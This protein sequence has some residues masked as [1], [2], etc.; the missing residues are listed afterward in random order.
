MES[1]KSNDSSLLQGKALER[2]FYRLKALEEF[3]KL[4][5]YNVG[6]DRAIVIIGCSFLETIL[7]HILIEFFPDDEK[8]VDVLLNYDKSLGT[9]SNKVR[10]IYC[11]GLIRKK[12]MDD[13]RLIGKI[14]NRFAH[15]L[16]VSFEDSDIASWCKSLKWHRE[17]FFLH[18][19]PSDATTRDIYQVGVN[20][21]ISYLNGV[22]SMAR[23]EKRV[24]KKE[25]Y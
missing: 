8:E 9:Y 1:K 15:D 16:S 23:G 12:V 20:T 3:S 10:M 7:E 25:L 24:L 14:R 18:E 6:D 22:V 13:L 21:L 19:T 4:F 17:V 5:T 11:L 2:Y